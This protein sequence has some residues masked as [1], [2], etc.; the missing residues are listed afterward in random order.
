MVFLFFSL[1]SFLDRLIKD[2]GVVGGTLGRAQQGS[3]E[4]YMK[5]MTKMSERLEW[6]FSSRASDGLVREAPAVK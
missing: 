3:R 6:A 5:K 1:R 2:V 4:I